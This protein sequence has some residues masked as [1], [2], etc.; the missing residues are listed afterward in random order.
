MMYDLTQASRRQ[1]QLL[2]EAA[3]DRLAARVEM[4]R[5]CR[6]QDGP[7]TLRLLAQAVRGRQA[8]PLTC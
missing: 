4:V 2:D 1:R 5:R 7:S 3:R 8:Q 6:A